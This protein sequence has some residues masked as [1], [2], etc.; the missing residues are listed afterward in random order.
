[1]RCARCGELQGDWPKLG[2][3][4][5]PRPRLPEPSKGIVYFG[6]IKIAWMAPATWA[7]ACSVASIQTAS[8]AAVSSS[9]TSPEG[10]VQV[11][12]FMA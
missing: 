2:C 7:V 12:P 9:T 5:E 1:V 8:P 3:L 11:L 10:S 6:S 4:G